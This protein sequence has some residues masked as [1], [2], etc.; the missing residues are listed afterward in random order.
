VQIV[1]LKLS[2]FRSTTIAPVANP[3]SAC[4]VFQNG[5]LQP[6]AISL[7]PLTS[8]N[9][10]QSQQQQPSTPSRTPSVPLQLPNESLK[11]I[12]SG[13]SSSSAMD[14]L[15]VVNNKRDSSGQ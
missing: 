14:V 13:N 5:T 8:P 1:K 6:I 11:S 7:A 9:H 15:K 2:L 12:K 10:A 4:F 3:D